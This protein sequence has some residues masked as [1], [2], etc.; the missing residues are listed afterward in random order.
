M[1]DKQQEE[2]KFLFEDN[3]DL[4]NFFFN[5]YFSAKILNHFQRLNFARAGFDA[6]MIIEMTEKQRKL[7]KLKVKLFFEQKENR[8]RNFFQNLAIVK[9]LSL[10]NKIK[11]KFD[12]FFYPENLDN[13]I[14]FKEFA[15]KHSKFRRNKE[16]ITIKFI[17]SAVYNHSKYMIAR[18]MKFPNNRKIIILLMLSVISYMVLLMSH[19][20]RRLKKAD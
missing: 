20:L 9:N 14:Y 4:V 13:Y 10:L 12:E 8:V 3:Y 7:V 11:N 15:G 19:L 1:K 5:F 6:D 17:F 18:F 16:S 2:E